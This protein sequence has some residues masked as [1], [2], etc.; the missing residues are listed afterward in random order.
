MPC[1]DVNRPVA[2]CGRA[3][4]RLLGAVILALQLA[5]PLRAQQSAPPAR[6][7]SLSTGLNLEVGDHTQYGVAIV[8]D[9]RWRWSRTTLRLR[10]DVAYQV[11]RDERVDETA[12]GVT[13]TVVQ[14]TLERYQA[15]PTMEWRFA[16]GVAAVA[17]YTWIRN[18]DQGIAQHHLISMGMRRTIGDTKTPTEFSTG[19]RGG[20]MHELETGGTVLDVP[21]ALF[22]AEGEVRTAAGGKVAAMVEMLSDLR[23]P[24][25]FRMRFEGRAEAPLASKLALALRVKTSYRNRT[26]QV[27]ERWASAFRTDHFYLLIEPRLTLRF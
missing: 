7:G 6:S 5:L 19:V 13:R 15:E 3:A 18:T 11:A 10:A 24:D 20:Y 25:D 23:T 1:V 17:D 14:S 4:P 16:P 2:P 21:T 22:D 27:V 12:N 9:V 8:P 26:V